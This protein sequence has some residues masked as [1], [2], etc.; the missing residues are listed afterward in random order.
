MADGYNLRWKTFPSHLAQV[1]RNLG[2]EGT[3]SDVILVSSD[4]QKP[5][6]AHKVVLSACSPVL[7]SLLVNN[8]HSHPLVYLAASHN[9]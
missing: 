5:I 8:P 6:P 2:E 1:F 3:F 9:K 4:D 7:K